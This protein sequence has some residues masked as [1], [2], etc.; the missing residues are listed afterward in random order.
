MP[1]PER[2]GVK[3]TMKVTFVTGV[4]PKRKKTTVQMSSPPNMMETVY[5]DDV[6]GQV[7]ARTWKIHTS[8]A[9]PEVQIIVDT[10]RGPALKKT[11]TSK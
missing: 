3:G 2:F 9:E 10:G 8:D 5:I 7:V 1:E 4:G 6:P 11:R